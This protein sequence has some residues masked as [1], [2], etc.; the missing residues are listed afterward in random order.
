MISSSATGSE[1]NGSRVLILKVSAKFG[2][3]RKA[4]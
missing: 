3:Y 4:G 2:N 1:T